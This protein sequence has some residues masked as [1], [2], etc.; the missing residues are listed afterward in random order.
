MMDLIGTSAYWKQEGISSKND[1]RRLLEHIEETKQIMT[2][3]F[4]HGYN[5]WIITF[6]G[7]KDSTTVVIL[8]LETILQK[9]LSIQ[10]IAV[11]QVATLENKA[12][13]TVQVV[14]NDRHHYLQQKPSQ[15]HHLNPFAKVQP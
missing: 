6:S 2:K 15:C 1:N 4:Y 3:F 10:R 7:G 13:E 14:T 9:D 5:R 8:A 12:E 11:T